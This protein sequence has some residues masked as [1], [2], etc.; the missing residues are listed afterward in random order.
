A[1]RAANARADLDARL[2]SASAHLGIFRLEAP[3]RLGIERLDLTARE[4]GPAPD[5][6]LA[7]ARVGARR[8]TERAA[9]DL[10]GLARALQIAAQK[11]IGALLRERAR[12]RF[13]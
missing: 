10:R 1:E 6:E 5:V 12:N 7:Q 2:A 13:G 4:S 11:A 9:H 8:E 3:Q